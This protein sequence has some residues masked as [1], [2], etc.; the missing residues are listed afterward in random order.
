MRHALFSIY[1]LTS[2]ALMAQPRFGVN[3]VR[4]GGYGGNMLNIYPNMPSH[5]LQK[6]AYLDLSFHLRHTDY[7]AAYNEPTAG[8]SLSFHDLGN[9]EV[10]GHAVGLQR[11]FQLEQRFGSE[12]PR[13]VLKENFGLGG[14]Y[15]TKPYDRSSNPGNNVFGS[16]L[17][18]LV[19]AGMGLYVN[20][21]NHSIGARF[22]YLHSSNGHTVLPN[23]GMNTP[24]WS[25]NYAYSFARRYVA[26]R[27]KFPETEKLIKTWNVLAYG[28][29]GLNQAGGTVR[30][31]NTPTYQ[32]HIIALGATYRYSLINR[33]SFTVEGY[34]NETYRL[35]NNVMQWDPKNPY[36]G[37]SALMLMAGHEFIYGRFGMLIQMGLNIYNPTLYR[38]IGEVEQPTTS[39]QLKSIIPGRFAVRYY[40]V[41]PDFNT[42]GL[43]VQA[44]IKSNMGQAD[45]LEF[46]IGT[47]IGRKK[48]ESE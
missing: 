37:S 40:V 25:L 9:A 8:Y 35:W 11:T 23:V 18:A 38:L 20:L 36:L 16:S 42:S 33:L 6:G 14:I 26:E 27:R 12:S 39:N 45:F 29:F 32:K 10:L 24:T 30:P 7:Y 13:F 22:D 28:G 2:F 3:E 47:L 34:N 4:L 48:A 31:T 1:F 15:T 46:G 17:S 21:N 44:A 19:S 43:F 5:D 41:S